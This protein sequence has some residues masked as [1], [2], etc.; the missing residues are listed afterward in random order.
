MDRADLIAALEKAEGPSRELD[1]EIALAIEPGEVVWKQVSG[2]MEVHPSIKRARSN[3]IGGYAF[4]HVPNFTASLDAALSLVPTTSW[5][6][7]ETRA[8]HHGKP[9]AWCM[10]NVLGPRSIG[11]GAT[12]AIA[13]CIAALRAMD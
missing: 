10:N 8:K 11:V 5:G 12:P 9:L 6:V 1:I 7:E 13:L 2:S 4:E 3:Y